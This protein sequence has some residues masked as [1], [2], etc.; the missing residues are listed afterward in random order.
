MIGYFYYGLSFS[1]FLLEFVTVFNS[2]YTFYAKILRIR[3]FYDI[4]S[5]FKQK[6]RFSMITYRKLFHLLLDMNI[7]KRNCRKKQE[8]QPP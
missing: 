7:K 8:L 5:T 4:I 6:E 2:F 1:V 3:Y